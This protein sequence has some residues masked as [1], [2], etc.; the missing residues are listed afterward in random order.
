MPA[1]DRSMRRYYKSFAAPPH[2]LNAFLPPEWTEQALCASA[3]PDAWFPENGGDP[4]S[5]IRR[6][7]AACPVKVECLE[8][9]LDNDEQHGWWGGAS[10]R[11]I[12][13]LRRLRKAS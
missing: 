11:Q 10:P 9:A 8:Y 2:T 3:D 13:A 4:A 5:A 7:C 6:I 1:A 12:A